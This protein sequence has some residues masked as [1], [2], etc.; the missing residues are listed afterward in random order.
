MTGFLFGDYYVGIYYVSSLIYTVIKRVVAAAYSVTVTSLTE[1]YSRGEIEE[2][3]NLLNMAVNNIIL[4]SIPATMGGILISEYIITVFA[5]EGYA[6]AIEP[7][8]ILLS[9]LP[10]AVMG[11]AIAYCLNMP[12]KRETTNLF[13][14]GVSAIENILLNAVLM[15]QMGISGAAIATLLSEATV[16]T[17]LLIKSRAF[18]Y[19]FDTG[20]ILSNSIKTFLSSF[21]FVIIYYLIR[22]TAVDVAFKLSL[23]I[24]VSAIV[25][26]LMN[27]ALKNE[28]F[29]RFMDS[30]IKWR[31]SEE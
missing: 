3:K 21:P 29:M 9:A 15:P 17:I 12:M 24:L 10:I 19:M 14:T 22:R 28:A 6:E 5:G 2:F 23:T 16:V 1:R 26:V 4:L 20:K 31:I 27:C 13:C 11:G 25:F 7:L 18:Y 8:R 30:M